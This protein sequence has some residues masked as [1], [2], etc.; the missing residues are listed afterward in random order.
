MKLVAITLL[1]A[2]SCFA[3]SQVA[4]LK[5]GSL[6]LVGP[7]VPLANSPK[8]GDPVDL[9]TGLYIRSNTDLHLKDSIPIQLT[10][11]YRNADPRSR[12]FG[13]GTSTSFD[14]FIIGDSKAFSYVELIL[15][16]GAASTTIVS[17]QAE[18]SLPPSSKIPIPRPS[19]TVRASTGTAKDGQS[20]S[21]MGLRTNCEVAAAT[22]SPDSA[23]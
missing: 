3:N 14:M 6:H 21:R 19:S 17:R 11:T 2:A 1:A 18:I 8:V 23:A 13:I 20:S 9:Q 5:S 4:D 12:A 10:R 7:R 16:D 22:V 15:S